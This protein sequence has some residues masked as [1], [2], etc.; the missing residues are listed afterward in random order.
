MSGKSR[1]ARP[2]GVMEAAL[3]HLRECET[4]VNRSSLGRK[5]LELVR[6]RVSQING[7]RFCIAMHH[8][9]LRDA[10][11][12]EARVEALQNWRQ[13]G[14]F[15]ERE[16]AALEWAEQ[17]TRLDAAQDTPAQ[18]RRVFSHQE[19]SELVLAVAMINLWNRIATGLRWQ[20]RKIP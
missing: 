11:E 1:N 6:L 12:S 16:Q 14:F 19:C 3:A 17:L 2:A 9:A 8:A 20:P 15:S 5:L 13:H 7:C 10:G 4:C 18:A